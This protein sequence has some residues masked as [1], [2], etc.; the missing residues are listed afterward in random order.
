MNYIIPLRMSDTT[1]PVVWITKYALT[2][3]IIEVRDKAL[4]RGDGYIMIP[5][6]FPRSFDAF[7]GRGDWHQDRAEAAKKADNMREDDCPFA[8]CR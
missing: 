6:D 4:K 2:Q 1:L 7:Y 5:G 8:H 3:G